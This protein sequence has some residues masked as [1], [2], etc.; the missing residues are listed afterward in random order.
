MGNACPV[1]HVNGVPGEA[2]NDWQ[3]LRGQ[4]GLKGSLVQQ[5]LLE[6]RQRC[7]C[8]GANGRS[9]YQGLFQSALTYLKEILSNGK[10]KWVLKC[11]KG[12]TALLKA[13]EVAGN[14]ELLKGNQGIQDERR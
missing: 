14:I 3:M 9:S 7:W 4:Q 1:R 8:C 13:P 11:V 5:E 10:M 2:N 6:K 12:R